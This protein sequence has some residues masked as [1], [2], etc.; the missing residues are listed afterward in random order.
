MTDLSDRL[1]PDTGQDATII[2]LVDEKSFADWKKGQPAHI[3]ALVEARR[4]LQDWSLP[5]PD[6][7]ITAVGTEVHLRDARGRWRLCEDYAE[8]LLPGWD[9]RR[10]RRAIVTAGVTLQ[11]EIEQRRWKLGALGTEA[12]AARLS[13]RLAA[14]GLSAQVVPSHGRLID[15]LPVTGGK[16]A[17]V[18]HLARRLGVTAEDVVVAGDSGNDLDMLREAPRGILVGNALPELAPLIGAP[19]LYRARAHHAAG[20]LEG[21]SHFAG[22]EVRG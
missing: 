21:L 14:E 13:A 11:P 18:R 4:V 9:P 20:V 8:T 22:T 15:V 7:F 2:H 5:Q 17:A 19:N 3:R 10:L 1:K 6:A 16:G 12:C